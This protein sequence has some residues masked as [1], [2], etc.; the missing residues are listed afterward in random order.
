[1]SLE[2]PKRIEEYILRYL[3][4]EPILMLDLVKMVKND[5][6]NTTKQAVYAAIRV[7]KKSEQIITYKGTASLNLTWLNSMISYFSLAK[8]NYTKIKTNEG[9]F[10]D[11]EDK[12]KIKY[13]FNNPIKADI[14][15][16]HVL[17]MLIERSEEKEPLFLYNPHEW[18]LLVRAENEKKLF[19]T[20]IKKG[21]QVLLTA[22]SSLFLDRYLKKFFDNDLS[23]Y[24][25][26]NEPLFKENNYYLNI[27]GDFLIEVWLDKKMSDKI[28]V[29]YKKT[30]SW[31]D[32]TLQELKKIIDTE[33]RMKIVISR[34]R[35]KAEK[36]KKSLKKHFV[37]K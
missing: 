17:Y 5:R 26:K 27:I 31:N 16:T 14:F 7:L 1:M 3:Q 22:G 33:S 10:I 13:Y 36:I 35:N 20:I 34:N 24:H 9:N 6:P 21:H 8:Y 15:W 12:E 11:L 30:E 19:D 2:K 18:F 37:L 25:V 32:E 28:E 29:F 23:Q 4:V